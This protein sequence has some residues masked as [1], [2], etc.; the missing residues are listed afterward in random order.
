MYII[1]LILQR[2]GKVLWDLPNPGR[3]LVVPFSEIECG[4]GKVTLA[5]FG[6]VSPYRHTFDSL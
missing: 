2:F 6:L 5:N 1:G 3:N 4:G